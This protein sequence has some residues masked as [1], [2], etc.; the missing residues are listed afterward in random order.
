MENNAKCPHCAR[1]LGE[2]EFKTES[3]NSCGYPDV[4]NHSDG[5]EEE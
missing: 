1:P 2:E 3:C 5:G 4:D